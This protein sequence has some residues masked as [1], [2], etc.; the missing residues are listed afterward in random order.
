MR[1]I[2]AA[3]VYSR[4]AKE[5]SYQDVSPLQNHLISTERSLKG[6]DCR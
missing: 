2:R 6:G 4:S 3:M 1:Q 5:T